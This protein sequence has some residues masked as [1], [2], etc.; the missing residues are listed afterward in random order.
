M[1]FCIAVASH[2]EIDSTVLLLFAF[3]QVTRSKET[4]NR[5]GLFS[6]EAAVVATEV[7]CSITKSGFHD[8]TT[9]QLQAHS[10]NTD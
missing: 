10:P 8:A 2:T 1:L 9:P 7:F 5:Q 6:R 3:I 4:S